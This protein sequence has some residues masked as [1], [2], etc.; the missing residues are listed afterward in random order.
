MERLLILT[1]RLHSLLCLY[2][3][4][5]RL[6]ATPHLKGID[7]QMLDNMMFIAGHGV[8]IQP[9]PLQVLHTSPLRKLST[10]NVS[11][12]WIVAKGYMDEHYT[13]Q[14]PGKRSYVMLSRWGVLHNLDI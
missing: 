10:I 6:L 4:P 3:N 8:A 12:F 5:S 14:E 11:P 9:T 13:I 2:S 1:P 7:V